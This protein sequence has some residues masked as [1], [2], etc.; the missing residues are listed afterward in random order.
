M[1]DDVIFN[2]VI[3]LGNGRLLKE[4]CADSYVNGKVI[5]NSHHMPD[6]GI[7][8]KYHAEL[9]RLMSRFLPGFISPTID[10]IR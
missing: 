5:M 7:V 4:G 2:G 9:V 10:S 8:I 1:S 6:D 3:I